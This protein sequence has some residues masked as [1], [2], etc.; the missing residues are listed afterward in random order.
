MELYN[1]A[2]ETT[3][4]EQEFRNAHPNT[5]FPEMLTLDII[6]DF[7]YLPVLQSPQPTPSISEVVVRNGV[8]TDANDNIVQKWS[9]APKYLEYTDANDV[10]HTAQAQLEA[11][12]LAELTAAKK[13]IIR[14]VDLAVDR[15]MK[16]CVGERTTEYQRA[17]AQARAYKAGGYVGAAEKSVHDWG[18]IK[19]W[20]DAQAADD[21]IAQADAWINAQ[22]V[23]RQNRLE[24]K[25]DMR[26]ATTIA[27]LNSAQTAWQG[28]ETY[29]R[30]ALGI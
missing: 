29:I 23:I 9:L 3:C 2:T 14:N 8:S 18:V 13:L 25:E 30:N 22:E 19:G 21:I 10:V 7:G 17:E 27:E 11:A 26:L 12:L 5:S 20:T 24:S 28:F 15:I 16:D 1:I 4:T 6:T